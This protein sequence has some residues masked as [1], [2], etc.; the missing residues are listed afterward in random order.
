LRGGYNEFI[1]D[2]DGFDNT[3]AGFGRGLNGQFVS[4]FA[5][6]NNASNTASTL[7]EQRGLTL[8]TQY[9]AS[10]TGGLTVSDSRCIN[11]EPNINNN[12]GGAV[13]VTNQY[14]LYYSSVNN[15]SLN[16]SYTNE[17]SLYGNTAKASAYNAGGFQMP[18]VTVS[19]LS[20][21]PQREGNTAYVTDNTAGTG[22][23][24]K[25]LVFYDGSNWKLSHDPS[26]TA[27]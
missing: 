13:T 24:A 6:N 23:V 22:S 11:M 16:S 27:A 5:K 17:Y 9:V 19:N 10:S 15:D 4:A 18:V 12:A 2:L 25:C 8:T 3:T 21:L 20:T 7:T 14:G 26:V 1:Y